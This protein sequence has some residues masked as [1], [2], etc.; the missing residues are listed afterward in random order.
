MTEEAIPLERAAQQL[1]RRAEALLRDREVREPHGRAPRSPEEVQRTLDELHLHQIELEMQNEELQ[2]AKAELEA[3]RERYFELYELAPVGYC[4]VTDEGV[5]IEGNLMLASL[6]GTARVASGRRRLQQ[7]IAATD[8]DIYYQ[9]RRQLLE[10]RAPQACE[11]R[12]VRPDGSTFWGQLC[13]TVG[14]DAAGVTLFRVFRPHKPPEVFSALA[15]IRE[16]VALVE[17]SYYHTGMALKLEA[18]EELTLQGSANE[19]SQ[20]LMNLLANALEA[21]RVAQPAQGKVTLG[22]GV[23][24]GLAC[25]T[26][27]D[28]GGGIPPAVFERLFERYFTT[29]EGGSGLG[30]YMSRQIVEQ[31]FGGRLEARNVD[32]GAEFAVLTPLAPGAVSE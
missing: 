27:R 10:T 29:R 26:V 3:A 18:A 19:Y 22:L 32:G 17:P 5:F 25:L 4:T 16:T 6:L 12:L 31:S 8:Q 30:L 28:N 11:L 2:R 23:R 9:H 14:E 24:D 7:L 21:L 1:R 15:K 13:S 20:V